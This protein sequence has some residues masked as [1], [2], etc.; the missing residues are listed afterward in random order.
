VNRKLLWLALGLSSALLIVRWFAAQQLGFGDAEALYAAYARHP[1]PVFR[2]HPGL[3]GVLARAIGGGDAP[4]PTAAHAVTAWLSTLAPWFAALA[5][6]AAGA[7]WRG[8]AA[9]TVALLIVP[10]L[11]IGLFGLTPDLPLMLLW[12]VA[13]GCA[14]AALRSS[15]G[16]LSALGLHLAAGAAAGMACNAKVSGLLLLAGLV[17]TWATSPAHR[18]T[19][20]P[21]AGLLI[22]SV[23]ISPVLM[24]EV[25]RGY[26]ML[27]H[28]L[29]D[30]QQGAGLSLRNLGALLGGQ[31][32]YLT[33]PVA[34]A[35]A[36]LARDLFKRRAESP[37][38]QLLWWTT[39]AC[40]PLVL[41]ACVSRVAEPHWIA[42][43]YLAL[44][45]HLARRIDQKPAILGPRLTYWSVAA[46]AGV[47]ALAHAWV[48][49]SIAPRWLGSA[50]E[51]RYDLANDLIAWRDG[52]PAVREALSLSVT[53]GAPPVVVVGPHWIVCAQLHA[54]LPG[55]VLVGCEAEVPD[56]FADWLPASTWERAPVLLYVSDDRFPT[57]ASHMPSRRADAE[58]HVDVER[59]GRVVRRITITRLVG[60]AHAE[61]L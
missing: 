55:T 7:S 59:G 30:T 41:L 37:I 57:A 48:L 38:D 20:A 60:T 31:L 9:A 51:P 21:W 32:L 56:D 16:S 12:Y 4:R 40:T 25:H 44:P 61:N 6:R 39:L 49:S 27:R 52:L 34:I 54:G 17:T 53:P 36:I 24:D 18:R 23:L 15:P 35:A 19:L 29:I 11:T 28:R 46:G 8:A 50:Y 13:I 43:L 58:W 45:L 47:C 1:Q 5:A 42:P 26:P 10:E 33:P 3:I 14:A 22:A 2:D